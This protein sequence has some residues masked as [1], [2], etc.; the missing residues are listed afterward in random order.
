[1]PMYIGIAKSLVEHIDSLLCLTNHLSKRHPRL[2][3]VA[4]TYTKG[5]IGKKEIHAGIAL[6]KCRLC[7]ILSWDI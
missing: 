2:W 5:K 7:K 4:V 1:M 3:E 6:S